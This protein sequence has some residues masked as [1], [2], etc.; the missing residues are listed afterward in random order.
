MIKLALAVGALFVFGIAA[1]AIVVLL[2]KTVQKHNKTNENGKE[3]N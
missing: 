1:Y 2:T 3:S